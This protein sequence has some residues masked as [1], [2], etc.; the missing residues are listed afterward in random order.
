FDS[1]VKTKGVRKLSSATV[2]T[3][4]LRSSYEKGCQ[5]ETLLHSSPWGLD[6]GL[7]PGPFFVE[8]V[9]VLTPGAP[10]STTGIRIAVAG[11]PRV[12][13]MQRSRHHS[14]QSSASQP[15]A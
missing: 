9:L 13:F 2:E 1:E 10:Q 8:R 4:Q 14:L 7:H 15:L 6:R 11:L 5:A 3:S 12:V